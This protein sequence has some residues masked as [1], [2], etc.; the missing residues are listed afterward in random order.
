MNNKKYIVLIVIIFSILGCLSSINQNRFVRLIFFDVG[1]GDA[2]L[3][4]L[5]DGRKILIDGGPDDKILLRLG[6]Y[7]NF[8]DRQIDWVILTHEHDDHVFGLVQILKRY[9]VGK[10]VYSEKSCKNPACST[11]FEIANETRVS[12]EKLKNNKTILF[13]QNCSMQLFPPHDSETK[14]VNNRSIALRLVCGEARLL[15]A[16]DGEEA[17]ENEL[18]LEHQNLSAD[19]FKASHHGS[20]TS[21]SQEFLE[22]INP[23]VV[24]ISVGENNTFG[25]P[26]E[27]IIERFKK[28]GIR[29]FRTDKNGNISIN[30]RWKS[31]PQ[32][33]IDKQ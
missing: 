3:V 22:A 30:F 17:R 10:I 8:F 27:N 23:K 16:G 32:L 29:I 6:S 24:I 21:N 20:K 25:H 1:Q 13:D 5:P 2:T 18:L 4:V 26:S 31:Y 28:M 15:L 7:L 12:L 14:N 9:Q 19:I 11:F 33:S